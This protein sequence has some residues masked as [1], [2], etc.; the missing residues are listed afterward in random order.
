MA[1]EDDPGQQP[2]Q[3]RVERVER[4]RLSRMAVAAVGDLQEPDAVPVRPDVRPVAEIVVSA[5]SSDSIVIGDSDWFGSNTSTAK[6]AISQI[7]ARDQRKTPVT[8]RTAA[9]TRVAT[10]TAGALVVGASAAA[11]GP[12]C[13]AKA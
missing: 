9:L 3:P 1:E 7:V 5:G 11:A 6:R 8:G 10:L 12:I 2:D 4:A 13:I